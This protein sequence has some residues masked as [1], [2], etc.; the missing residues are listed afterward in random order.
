MYKYVDSPKS[1]ALF[2]QIKEVV[3]RSMNF[4]ME[5][6]K[7]GSDLYLLLAEDGEA[8]GTFEFTPYSKSN[9][10][11][12]SLFQD[13]VTEEMKVMEVDSLAVLPRYRGQLGRPGICLMIDYAEQHGYTH[14]VGIADPRFFRSMNEKYRIRATPVKEQIYFKGAEAIP[15]LFHLKEVYS[16]K[17]NPNYSW[18]KP[19]LNQRKV[20]VMG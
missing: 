19:I 20:E 1:L 6:A 4:E 10:Y 11:I 18:Y 12:H 16:N 7:E 5:H 8:G 3:W 13:V 14:A 17:D 15:T 9:S 2:H